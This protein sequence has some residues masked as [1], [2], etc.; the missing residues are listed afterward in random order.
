MSFTNLI[1]GSVFDSG[2]SMSNIS[3]LDYLICAAFALVL[4]LIIGIVSSYKNKTSKSFIAAMGLLP[5]IVQTVILLVNGNLGAAVAVFGV[6]S[7]VRFRSMPGSAKDI[8]TVFE[9]MAVGL[10][11]GMGFVGLA[12]V[13]TLIVSVATIIYAQLPDSKKEPKESESK[14]KTLKIV[15]PEDIDYDSD[16][17]ET[18]DKHCSTWS[19]SSVETTNMGSLFQLKYAIELKDDKATKALL[20]DL[21]VLNGNLRVSLNTAPKDKEKEKILL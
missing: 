15:V 3:S 8:V 12:C 2:T 1:L 14:A 9:A 17:D 13:M 21:R 19:L 10:A 20:D 11:C 18:L 5:V 6:F 7:L 4:G 16:F